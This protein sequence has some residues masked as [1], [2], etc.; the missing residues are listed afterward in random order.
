[1][2]RYY[3]IVCPHCN[4]IARVEYV[5]EEEAFSWDGNLNA[6]DREPV[7]FH[8]QASYND[9]IVKCDYH[10]DWSDYFDWDC[11]F[12]CHEC[13]EVLDDQWYIRTF[14]GFSQQDEEVDVMELNKS[15]VPLKH[16]CNTCNTYTKI[17]ADGYLKI[18]EKGYLCVDEHNHWAFAR[19]K[20]DEFIRDAGYK[21]FECEEEIDEVRIPDLCIADYFSRNVEV[22][23]IFED[24][25]PPR[26]SG[27]IE[28]R[29]K[30][31]D[32]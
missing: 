19:M 15:I 32:L 2:S 4:S 7:Y 9:S 23:D 5:I 25:W 27:R 30:I 17:F 21:C 13:G 24:F 20:A 8:D 10:N 29:W 18:T 3:N 6:W 22:V 31:L 16:Y 14:V 26:P 12:T 28:S 1:M 11:V